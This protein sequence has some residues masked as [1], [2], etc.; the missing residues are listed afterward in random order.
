MALQEQRGARLNLLGRPHQ[1]GLLRRPVQIVGHPA[2]GCPAE[3]LCRLGLHECD[4]LPSRSVPNL[5]PGS[6]L[7]L[8]RLCIYVCLTLFFLLAFLNWRWAKTGGPTTLEEK[9]MLAALVLG[10][11]REGWGYFKIGT[12]RPLVVFWGAPLASLVA[13]LL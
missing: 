12:Y 7:A 5:Y 1:D 6:R 4:I 10:G 3:R 13:W 2:R 9:G 8:D 11:L